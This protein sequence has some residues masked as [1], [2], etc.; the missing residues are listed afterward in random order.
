LACKVWLNDT[1]ILLSYAW[2]VDFHFLTLPS[3]YKNVVELS[4]WT[5]VDNLLCGA[6]RCRNGHLVIIDN[7]I[8]MTNCPIEP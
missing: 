5:M 7:S 6:S 3:I 8:A 1:N 4:M 2:V